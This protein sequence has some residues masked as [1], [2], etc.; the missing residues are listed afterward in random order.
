MAVERPLHRFVDAVEAESWFA[1]HH[2]A[3]DGIMVAIAKKASDVPTPTY[4]QLVELA[5]RFGWIDSQTRRLDDDC[6]QMTF[7][8]RRP[9][10]PWSQVNREKVEALIII[11]RMEPSGLAEVDR[12]RANG[13]WDAAYARSSE[14]EVP[15]DFLA[16]LED[17]PVA[18]EF[19]ATLSKQNT[20]A[21]YYRLNDAKR[22]ET[23]ARRIESFVA[24]FA[25]GE[26]LY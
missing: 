18:K 22:P 1:A 21:V 4:D 15:A 5:L 25:R 10:S 16:A 11:G 12:A 24:M 13:R 19:F 26:K 8:P 2:D 23:R 3:S 14:A 9:R 17:N 7:T 6:F 20:F